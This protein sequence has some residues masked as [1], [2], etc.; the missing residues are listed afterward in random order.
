MLLWQEWIKWNCP[1]EKGNRREGSGCHVETRIPAFT[2]KTVKMVSFLM[3]PISIHGSNP[4]DVIPK[5][6]DIAEGVR[7]ARDGLSCGGERGGICM[8]YFE[9]GI[10]GVKWFPVNFYIFEIHSAHPMLDVGVI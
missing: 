2:K 7:S 6:G 3:S 9:I 10:T 5:G 1:K 8:L 4:F